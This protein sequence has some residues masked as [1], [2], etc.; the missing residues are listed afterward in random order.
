MA[1]SAD[2]SRDYPGIHLGDLAGLARFQPG[3]RL[4][5]QSRIRARLSVT[6]TLLRPA[7]GDEGRVR[8]LR[9]GEIDNVVEPAATEPERMPLPK[10]C[11]PA[12]RSCV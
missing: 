8:L 7:A 12:P 3:F 2:F 1:H 5:G 9:T 10:E 11:A 6:D 4:I